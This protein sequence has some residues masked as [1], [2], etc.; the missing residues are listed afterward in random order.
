MHYLGKIVFCLL[1]VAIGCLS[2]TSIAADGPAYQ[3][4]Y[5]VTLLPDKG[6]GIGECSC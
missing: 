1:V 3:L 6:G 2:K 5:S 4:D